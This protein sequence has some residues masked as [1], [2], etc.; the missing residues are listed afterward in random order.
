[1][2]PKAWVVTGPLRT[3][4]LLAAA[5]MLRFECFPPNPSS[6]QA[7]AVKATASIATVKILGIRIFN[8]S[9]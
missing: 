7:V 4:K 6:A 1:M 2:V 5:V 9:V 8:S 3:V